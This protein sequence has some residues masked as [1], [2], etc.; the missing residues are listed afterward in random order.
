MSDTTCRF[1]KKPPVHGDACEWCFAILSQ[2]AT[3]EDL[4]RL[5]NIVAQLSLEA[6]ARR[7]Q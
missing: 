2:I 7:I 3:D 1:C 4:L 5:K 6:A